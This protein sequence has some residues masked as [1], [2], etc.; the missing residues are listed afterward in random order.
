M[1]CTTVRP[2]VGLLIVLGG[3]ACDSGGATGPTDPA[4]PPASQLSL[5]APNGSWVMDGVASAFYPQNSGVWTARLEHYEGLEVLV[6]TGES[7]LGW[8]DWHW[9][10]GIS[11]P[12][13]EPLRSGQSF[14]GLRHP[15]VRQGFFFEAMLL[16]CGST[17]NATLHVLQ[18]GRNDAVEAV[19]ISFEH[20]CDLESGILTGEWSYRAAR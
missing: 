3:A 12:A 19:R 7:K 18:R 13:S 14:T 11:T 16:G 20:N 2:L 6:L 17:T 1:R 5:S 10:L 9:T 15:R 8:A 4:L